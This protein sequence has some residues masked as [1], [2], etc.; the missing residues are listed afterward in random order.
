[1][2][3][4]LSRFGVGSN[5]WILRESDAAVP[6]ERH[7]RAGGDPGQSAP[8]L[9]LLDSRLRGNDVVG[10][11]HPLCLWP[12]PPPASLVPRGGGHPDCRH[13]GFGYPHPPCFA[14]SPLPTRG[15]EA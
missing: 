13:C 2:L 7:P 4:E 1:P 15:R 11:R 3:V 6:A 9:W 8:C 12:P 10:G 14:W 5:T